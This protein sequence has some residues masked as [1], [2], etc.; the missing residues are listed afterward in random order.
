MDTERAQVIL[1][2]VLISVLLFITVIMM[3]CALKR[4]FGTYFTNNQKVIYIPDYPN[5]PFLDTV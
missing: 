4:C 5:E 3:Y 1:T 2:I